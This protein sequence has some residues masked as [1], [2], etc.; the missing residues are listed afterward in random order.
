MMKF[1]YLAYFGLLLYAQTAFGQ[2]ISTGVSMSTYVAASPGVLLDKGG[3]KI[4]NGGFGSDL[5][6]RKG[7]PGYFY[8]ITDRGPNV[9]ASKSSQKVFAVPSFNPQIGK[10]IIDG[11]SI[12]LVSVVGLKDTK[13]R[14][15]TGLPNPEGTGGTG[16]IPIDLNQKVLAT[17]SLGIDSEGLVAM[18]DGSF[19][20]SDEYGPHIVHFAADGKMLERV[21]P[22]SSPRSIPKVFTTRQPNHGMEGLTILPD[23]MTL[24]G[25]IQS[26][27]YNPTKDDTKS[28]R[29]VRVLSYN[30]ITGTSKQY[31][32]VLE[33]T[34]NDISAITALDKNTMLV[35]ERDGDMK[36]GSTKSQFKNIYKISIA[37]ATDISD[38]AN[39]PNGLLFSGKTIE[40]LNT[41]S[42]L[43]GKGITPVTKTLL[44]NLLDY[45]FLHDKLEGLAVIDNYTLAVSNDD[46]FGITSD[47]D[48]GI[49]AKMVPTANSG[50]SFIDRNELSI[51]KLTSPLTPVADNRN[52]D[53]AA[54]FTLEQN[55]PNPF[56][57]ATVIRYHL[58]A[59]ALVTVKVY[60]LLGNVVA[61]L[62][63][64]YQNAGDHTVPFETGG[65]ASGVYYYALC[66]GE[67]RIVNKMILLK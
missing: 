39:K 46:D 4:F 2:T 49:E 29:I 9:D 7:E 6:I 17:D 51:I 54:N 45:G 65:L 64:V 1:R 52:S 3:V 20:V 35:V 41:A 5:A 34:S 15:L 60:D 47:G 40:Q 8:I 23:G 10:F 63:N 27:L 21:N 28:S 14:L 56:N 53:K 59:N 25:M 22:F 50:V 13:G 24:I 43:K 61:V 42:G 37:T 38:P 57:N 16:E 26:P 62:T 44:C 11:D 19:W 55:Y 58:A 30:S 18:E 66:A 33:N 67:M 36:Y 12:R 32:Y 48:N 31:A